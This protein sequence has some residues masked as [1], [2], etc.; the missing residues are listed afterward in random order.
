MIQLID[1]ILNRKAVWRQGIDE[2]DRIRYFLDI[3][4]GNFTS[5]SD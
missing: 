5:R 2:P 4:S 3:G 1:C